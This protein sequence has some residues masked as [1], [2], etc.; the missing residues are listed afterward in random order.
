MVTDNQRQHMAPESE[1]VSAST[2]LNAERPEE[3]VNVLRYL[4]TIIKWRHSLAAFVFLCVLAVAIYSFTV[5]PVYEATSIF[6]PSQ[7]DLAVLPI[8]SGLG[9]LARGLGF[10]PPSSADLYPVLAASKAVMDRVLERQFD[11]EEHGDGK[12]LIEILEVD[13]GTGLEA[14]TDAYEVLRTMVRLR[15][16]RS[17]GVVELTV[18]ASESRLAADLAN[19]FVEELNNYN[20]YTR[21]SR[22]RENRVF[23]EQRLGETE[24]A[25]TKVEQA[26]T[27]FRQR[28]SSVG[29]SP[30]LLLEQGRLTR[31]VQI[32]EALFLT[33]TQQYELAKIEERR[34]IPVIDVIDRAAPPTSRSRPARKLL[35]LLGVMVSLIV[36]MVGVWMIDHFKSLDDEGETKRMVT[37]WVGMLREDI[38]YPRRLL[39]RMWRGARSEEHGK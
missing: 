16:D 36:G 5:R 13:G 11:T 28:N 29:D 17:R 21:T 39:A 14:R 9:G 23:V 20:L 7:Q 31:G 27:L 12:T 38:A 24:E 1:N 15:V 4:H 32:Q 10:L 19:A 26:L 22:A 8:A 6:L 37:Q 3:G 30:Q 34:D 25:L 35:V 33:L 2:E 18:A